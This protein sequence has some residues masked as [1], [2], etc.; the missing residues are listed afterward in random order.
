M[1]N[2]LT[3]TVLGDKIMTP[4]YRCGPLREAVLIL[5][6]C[7]IRYFRCFSNIAIFRALVLDIK[8]IVTIN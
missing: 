4:G 2:L 3:T 5:S 7:L 6:I 1:N 8:N